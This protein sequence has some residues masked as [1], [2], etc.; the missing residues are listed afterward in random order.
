MQQTISAWTGDKMYWFNTDLIGDIKTI[1]FS[2]QRIS[3]EKPH[4]GRPF[5]NVTWEYFHRSKITLNAKQHSS[6]SNRAKV[7]LY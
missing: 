6:E 5:P 1:E 2:Q 4:R 7:E 3:L